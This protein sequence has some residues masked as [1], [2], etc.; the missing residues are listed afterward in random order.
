MR[1][2][3]VDFNPW[4]GRGVLLNDADEICDCFD[5]RSSRSARLWLRRVLTEHPTA[6]VVASPMDDLPVEVTDTLTD[7]GRTPNWLSPTLTRQLYHVARPWNLPR[8]LHRARLLAYLHRYHVT[9]EF[10]SDSLMEFEHRLARE[11][12]QTFH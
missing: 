1:T 9:P 2:V 5:S 12:L 11:T 7:L 3:A 4:G 6:N 8:K 10:L